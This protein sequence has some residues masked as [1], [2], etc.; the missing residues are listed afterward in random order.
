MV[1]QGL[2][3]RDPTLVMPVRYTTS[4]AT[5]D[6]TVFGTLVPN[7]TLGKLAFAPKSVIGFNTP[8][9]TTVYADGGLSPTIVTFPNTSQSGQ[10][11]FYQR[12]VDD[13]GNVNGYPS[14]AMNNNVGLAASA[15]V[16]EVFDASAPTGAGTLAGAVQTPTSGG[17]VVGLTRIFA[18]FNGTTPVELDSVTG[19]SVFDFYAPNISG[20]SL[21]V[22]SAATSATGATS[23]A[24]KTGLTVNS[25]GIALD[26]PNVPVVASPAPSAIVP[27]STGAFTFTGVTGVAFASLECE[28]VDAGADAGNGGADYYV[29]IVTTA[30]SVTAS[31]DA[32]LSIG[33]P[34]SGS[35][36]SFTAGS[37]S[38]FTSVDAASGPGGYA[39]SYASDFAVVDG[40]YSVSAPLSVTAQ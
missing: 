37:M 38:G 15:T 32:L 13:A 18:I 4:T 19:P 17:W 11:I 31:Q 21:M 25:T 7:L 20:V 14:V 29:H 26:L 16:A 35:P 24:W 27:L 1:Y 3:R 12:T 9:S 8:F 30:T 28:G 10:L 2:T 34:P 23:T 33:L 39:N 22:D 40:S 6:G 36:C 5:V